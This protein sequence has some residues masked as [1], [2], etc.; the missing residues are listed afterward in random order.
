MNKNREE[1][2]YIDKIMEERK[3]FHEQK[4]PFIR[5][6]ILLIV[7]VYQK[8]GEQELILQKINLETGNIELESSIPYIHT[9]SSKWDLYE[10]E[11]SPEEKFKTIK[12]DIDEIVEA[13]ADAMQILGE[14]DRNQNLMYPITNFIMQFRARINPNFILEYLSKIERECRFEGEI[15]ILSLITR[16]KPI[17]LA[18][19]TTTYENDPIYSLEELDYF[20]E[21]IFDLNLPIEVYVNIFPSDVRS[22]ILELSFPSDVRSEIFELLFFHIMTNCYLYKKSDEFEEGKYCYIFDESKLFKYLNP[23]IRVISG[24]KNQEEKTQ[25]TLN[26]LKF[27]LEELEMSY[28]LSIKII[29]FFFDDLIILKGEIKSYNLIHVWIKKHRAKI[30]LKVLNRLVN[31]TIKKDVRTNKIS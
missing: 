12:E 11:P 9:V 29:D 3:I 18:F 1:L 27:L 15:H 7:R 21:K 23:F 8:T 24:L 10:I 25:Y 31:H 4:F 17:T 28:S 2:N 30:S 22:E 5:D 20:I 13:G 16:L 19:Y 26:L 14:F 6:D